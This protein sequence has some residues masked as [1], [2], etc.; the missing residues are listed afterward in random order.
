MEEKNQNLKDLEK[1]KKEIE[2]LK[3]NIEELK[4]KLEETEKL[5]QEYLKGW[6]RERADFL[7]Y[8]ME[9]EKRFEKF[10]ERKKEKLILEFLPILDNF[11]IAKKSMKNE[12]DPKI[13]GFLQIE[14]QILEFLRKLGLEEIKTEKEKLNLLEHEVV[15]EIDT[16]EFETGTVIEE[17]QKGYKLNGKVIRPAKVKVA[18]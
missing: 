5:K 16:D 4:K 9:E 6:Q 15:E 14:K 2:E 10:F 7:N 17:V 18:K 11:E 13:E 8:R 3:K 12:R 1:L